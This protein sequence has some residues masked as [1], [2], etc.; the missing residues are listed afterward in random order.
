MSEERA[1][2]FLSRRRLRATELLEIFAKLKGELGGGELGGMTTPVD[3]LQP[4]F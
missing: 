2:E 3:P 4:L 1:N